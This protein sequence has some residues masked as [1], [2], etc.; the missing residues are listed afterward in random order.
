MIQLLGFVDGSGEIAAVGLLE[1]RK[2]DVTS[3]GL[4]FIFTSKKWKYGPNVE[5]SPGREMAKESIRSHVA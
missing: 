5:K 4:R 1:N 2:V 3:R